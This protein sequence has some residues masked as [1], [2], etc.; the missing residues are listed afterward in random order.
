[1]YCSNKS[2]HD[3]WEKFR[4]WQTEWLSTTLSQWEMIYCTD[5]R[6]AE[7]V[8]SMPGEQW[9][10]EGTAQCSAVR[11]SSN[12]KH[13][14]TVLTPKLF[15]SSKK[16]IIL[17]SQTSHYTTLLLV[18][19]YMC[20]RKTEERWIQLMEWN[21]KR[22]MQTQISA[23]SE[24]EMWNEYFRNVEGINYSKSTHT[25]I[26]LESVSGGVAAQQCRIRTKCS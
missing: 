19:D 11:G 13:L 1:M 8:L 2:H 15:V 10:F 26:T 23:T 24:H 4:M 25:K 6:N 20:F 16:T 12:Y 7:P 14:E 9:K 5:R 18:L 21:Q 3:E 17:L 22:V